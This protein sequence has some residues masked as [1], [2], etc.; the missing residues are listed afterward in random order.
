MKRKSSLDSIILFV[1]CDD[2]I[3]LLYS[4][5]N[6]APFLILVRRDDIGDPVSQELFTARLRGL[7]YEGIKTL[8]EIYK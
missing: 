8:H 3:S 5:V 4:L 6:N 1:I 2:K 7:L